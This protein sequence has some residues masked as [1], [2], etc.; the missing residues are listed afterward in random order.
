[1]IERGPR[2]AAAWSRAIAA[3]LAFAAW[4]GCSGNESDSSR[5][6]VVKPREPAPFQLQIVDRIGYEVILERLKGKVVLVDCWATWCLPCIEQLPHSA[7]LVRRH[8]KADLAVVTL[9]LDEPA[10]KDEVR[11]LLVKSGAGG[12]TNLLSEYGSGSESVVAFEVPG[13]ALPHYKLYDRQGDLRQTFAL[14]PA[15]KK[16]FTPADVDQAV[17]ELLAE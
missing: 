6:R 8:R 10:D 4:A 7:E 11:K 16:Q 12:L 13:G 17:A 3:T 2:T 15:A 1:M 5:E 14:D 9:S